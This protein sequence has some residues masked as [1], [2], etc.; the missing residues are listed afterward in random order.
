MWDFHSSRYSDRPLMVSSGATFSLTMITIKKTNK[1]KC[2]VCVIPQHMLMQV[3]DP[4]EHHLRRG[5]KKLFL[6]G[7]ENKC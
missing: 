1:A 4:P 2:R 7:Q 3:G 5:E 6:Q